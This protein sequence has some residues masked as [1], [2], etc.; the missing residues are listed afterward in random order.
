L[1]LNLIIRVFDFV[2]QPKTC[3]P[4]ASCARPVATRRR[5]PRKRQYGTRWLKWGVRPSLARKIE[6]FVEKVANQLTLQGMTCIV[7]HTPQFKLIAVYHVG[8]P[9]YPDTKVHVA[10]ADST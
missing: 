2:T 9:I 5:S 1:F 7:Q 3:S 8:H 6:Q 10:Y 4:A